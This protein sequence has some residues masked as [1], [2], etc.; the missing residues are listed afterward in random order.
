MRH[1]SEEELFIPSLWHHLLFPFKHISPARLVISNGIRQP[2]VSPGLFPPE[3]SPRVEIT[4]G[5]KKIIEDY[6]STVPKGSAGGKS[7]FPLWHALREG[8]AELPSPPPSTVRPGSY[9][10]LDADQPAGWLSPE[11]LR[12]TGWAPIPPPKANP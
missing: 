3:S 8:S 5:E 7:L 2:S 6:F 4:I 10:F 9:S 12:P 1:H 11:H